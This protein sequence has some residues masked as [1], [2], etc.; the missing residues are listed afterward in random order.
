MYYVCIEDNRVTSVLNYEPSVPDNVVVRTI[1][2]KEYNNIVVE[3]SHHIDVETMSV[4]LNS[5]EVLQA[6]ARAAANLEHE[7]FLMATDWKVLRHLREKAL[8]VPT[9]LSDIQYLELERE[10]QKH[11]DDIKR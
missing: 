8:G 7:K 10:R 5:L 1:T 11:A 4:K 6:Q 9:S 2:D 3:K